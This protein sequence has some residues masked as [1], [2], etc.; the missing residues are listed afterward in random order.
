MPRKIYYK[1]GYIEDK[2]LVVGNHDNTHIVVE[3]DFFI[4][5]LIYCPKYGIEITL[6][7]TGMI[8]LHGICKAIILKRISGECTVDISDL[9]SRDLCWET[10]SGKLKLLLSVS[11]RVNAVNENVDI[12]RLNRL[13]L[14]RTFA[15]TIVAS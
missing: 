9:D 15:D 1:S 5:G 7:G 4:N 6:K 3:G 14:Q 8:S 13:N 11:Q 10:V 2:N 12:H